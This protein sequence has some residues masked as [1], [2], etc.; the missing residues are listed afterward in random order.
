LQYATTLLKTVKND[1]LKYLHGK[2]VVFDY[3]LDVSFTT[4]QS[5]VFNEL[6]KIPYGKT[7]SYKEL[8]KL[9]G[10][11]ARACGRILGSNP[12]PIIIPCHRVIYANGKLG[13]FIGGLHWKRALLKLEQS[14]K[15]LF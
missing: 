8:A 7:I 1:I 5:K 9:A 15:K 10:T 11:S 4:S 14:G 2:Q 13:G 3:P 6:N 12:L